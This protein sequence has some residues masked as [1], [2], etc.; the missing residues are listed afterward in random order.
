M[1]KR[2][3]KLLQQLWKILRVIW[4]RGRAASQLRYADGVWIPKDEDS[5]NIDQFRIISLLSTEGKI[6]FSILSRWLSRFLLQNEYIDTSVQKGGISGT[7]GCLEHKGAVT[8]RKE[9]NEG[10]GDLVVLWLDLSNAYRSIPEK[11]VEEALCSHHI[12]S[13]FSKLI[14]DYY[15]NFQLRVTTG[16]LTSEWH[17]LERGIITGC[18]IS[19][20]LFAL[21]MNMCGG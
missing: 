4:R 3:P 7:P 16:P 15:N 21:A 17:S 5:K 13:K 8:Q 19:V 12:P 11:L 10:K 2:C 20:T 6:F 9:A 1:Y 18:T 14:L